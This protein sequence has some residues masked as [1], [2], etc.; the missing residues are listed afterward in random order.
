MLLRT[1][2]LSNFVVNVVDGHGA[3]ELA[4]ILSRLHMSSEYLIAAAFTCFGSARA[5]V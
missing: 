2:L 4:V 3:A 1:R 5:P